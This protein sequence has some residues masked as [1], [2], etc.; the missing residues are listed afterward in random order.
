M[1]NDDNSIPPLLELTEL[2]RH[3]ISGMHSDLTELLA[4][5][6]FNDPANKELLMLQHA[7][8][9]GQRDQLRKLLSY[10]DEVKQM[11]ADKAAETLN[12]N[13]EQET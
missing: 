13:S 4:S 3:I 12:L 5:W 7:A 9:S 11:A 6:R 8:M 10:D 1:D 2:Q